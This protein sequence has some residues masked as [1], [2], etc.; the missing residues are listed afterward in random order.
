M[1]YEIMKDLKG[2]DILIYGAGSFGREMYEFLKSEA[3]DVVA[4]LDRDAEIIKEYCGRPVYTLDSREV[5]K[6]KESSIVL[7]TIVMDRQKRKS[8]IRDIIESG[9][10]DLREAQYY[11][12][13]Q[14]TPE[15]HCKD[16]EQFYKSS[17]EDIEK[18]YKLLSDEKSQR[19][20][21][22]NINA[23]I[24]GDY[25]ACESLEDP[26]EDQYFPK[27]VS[28]S[29]GYDRFVDC[30]GFVGDTIEALLRCCPG[31]HNVA[32]FEPYMSNYRKLITVAKTTKEIDGVCFPCAVGE[33]NETVYFSSGTGSGHISVKGDLAVPCISLDSAIS[34]FHPTFIKMDIEG[35]EPAAL[36]GACDIIKKDRPDLA[37]CVYHNTD[38]IWTIPL[39]LYNIVPEYRFYLRSYNAF[40]METVL[41]ASI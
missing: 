24:F 2:R 12:S 11:R 13:L 38:H 7:F 35:A 30:G 18:T 25:S 16:I 27:D 10:L 14:I 21:R 37:I 22:S 3:I 36:R 41:Y 31:H 9:F 34:G 33:R 4:F 8:L 6:Y 17:R 20:Y 15:N 39:L 5:E 32:S 28:F 19:I 40:T 1:M 29:K 23:L 26:M